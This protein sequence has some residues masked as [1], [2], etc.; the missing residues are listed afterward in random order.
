MADFLNL[1][2]LICAC[3]GAMAFGILA[4]YGLLRTGFALM[5]PRDVRPLPKPQAEPARVS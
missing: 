4:A 2:L 5:R 1:V 3:V